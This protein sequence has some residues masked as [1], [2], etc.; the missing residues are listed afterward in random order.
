[1]RNWHSIYEILQF[2]IGVLYVALFFVGLGTLF[3]ST[4]LASIFTVD[5]MVVLGIAEASI[6]LGSFLIIN[7]PL[8][9]LVRLVTRKAGSATS[10][11]SAIIGY[12]A[13][14]VM[15]MCFAQG[16]LPQTAYSSILG[17][18]TTNTAIVGTSGARY[19]LQTGAIATIVITMITLSCFNRTRLH[20]EYR[21]FGFIS[22]EV[23]CVIQ[24]IV[25][26]MIAGVVIAWAWPA[27]IQFFLQQIAFISADT[28]NPINLALYGILDRVSN[29]LNMSA[30]VRTPFWYGTSGGSWINMAGSNMTGD[31]SIWTN[32]ITTSSLTGMTGR[33]ITP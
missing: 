8:L 2:P 4:A 16:S 17:L 12:V 21:L 13:Y 15:T 31:V 11:L 33:F 22:R 20:N 5:N 18:S 7:F 29:I 9:F 10:I 1:M 28:T 30:L 19:P 25:F 6:R 32:Q 14:L 27:F 23:W 3:I 26:C 24:T